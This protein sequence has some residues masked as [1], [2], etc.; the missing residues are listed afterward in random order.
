MAIAL[1]KY[2]KLWMMKIILDTFFSPLFKYMWCKNSAANIRHAA[3]G[4][5]AAKAPRSKHMPQSEARVGAFT[6]TLARETL[7]GDRITKKIRE[8]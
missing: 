5:T 6:F 8:N 3:H 4:R 1:Y 7:E 2:T